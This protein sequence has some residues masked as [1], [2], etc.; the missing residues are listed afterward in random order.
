MMREVIVSV[1]VL[2]KLSDIVIYLR[3]ELKLSESAA[4]AYRE[5]FITFIQSFC[6]KVD[7]PLCRF[8]KWRIYGYRCAVF[9]KNWILAYE[10]LE[11]GVIV[12]DLSHTSLLTE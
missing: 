10:V 7:H 1:Q 8:K 4:M 6:V 12:R 2:D 11:E 5:R 3:D 9:E